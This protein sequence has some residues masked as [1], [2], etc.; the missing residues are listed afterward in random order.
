M[1]GSDA[2]APSSRRHDSYS[3]TVS[4]ETVADLLLRYLKLEGVT[5]IFGVPGG[6]VATLL[7]ALK[8]RRG[9][10]D[11]VVCR[12]ETGAAYAADG[13]F[14]ATGKLGVVLVTTGPGATNALTGAM[15]AQAGGSAVLVISGEVNEQY[16]GMGYLQEGIDAGLN[17]SAIYSAATRYSSVVTDQ[18]NFQ[19]L[20]AQALRDALSI[21]RRAV[22]LSMPNNVCAETV[23]EVSIPA[24]PGNYRA[25]PAGI[26]AEQVSAALDQ[27]LACKRPL[28]MVG[29]GCRRLAPA[30]LGELRG[31]AERYGIPVMTTADGKGIFPESHEL[32]LRV[33]GFAACMWPQ[34]WLLPERLQPGA[35]PYDGLLVLGSSLN[36]LGTNKWDPMLIPRGPFIQVDMDQS[37][38]GRAFHVSLGIVG[39]AGAFLSEA[40]RQSAH[41]PP[42]AAAVKERKEFVARIKRERSPFVDPAQ[43]ASEAAPIQPAALVRVLQ[44]EL[45]RDAMILLDAGNCAGWGA[46]YFEIGAPRAIHSAL[47]MGPMGF[48]VGGA[49]GAKTGAPERCVAALVGDGA[50]L[51]HGAEV[52]TAAAHKL[53]AIWIVLNDDDLHMVS[54]GQAHFFP[55]KRDPDIWYELYRLGKPTLAEFSRALG[56]DAFEIQ[57]PAELRAAMP[58]VLA[59]A[60]AGR[61]QVVVAKIDFKAQ[62]P[63]YN[64]DYIS[65]PAAPA[66]TAPARA[67]RHLRGPR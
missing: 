37:I 1:T 20:L 12:H 32:S 7:T 65:V 48:A 29:N 33:Y 55:D 28:I 5:H 8:D 25:T 41:R 61:P 59:G 26:S 16:S 4:G 24:S 2:G 17:V 49:L 43:Y 13:Y 63:Y 38:I 66:A 64:P 56:A 36:D 15:N 3:L 9:E 11:Y 21:P 39:D 10:L 54:Q 6:G 27:L 45:P 30:Q 40:A 14:R 34:Y 51:M 47:A 62:P 23:A 42:V 58:Q 53:G 60:A 57:S 31:L 22:H 35:P 67:G 44:K 46:H 18:S 52:S 19:T 50:F